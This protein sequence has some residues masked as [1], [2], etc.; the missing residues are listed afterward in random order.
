MSNKLRQ[1]W[2]KKTDFLMKHSDSLNDIQLETLS[3]LVSYLDFELE[4][5]MEQSF[6]L[7]R[8][9]DKMVWKLG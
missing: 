2:R 6:G 9:Y 7:N 1:S 8:M 4:L 5:S 3:E